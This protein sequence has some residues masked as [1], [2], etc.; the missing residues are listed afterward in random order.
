MK[1][2]AILAAA[3][4]VIAFVPRLGAHCDSLK[5]PVVAAAQ[6]ALEKGDVKFVLKWVPAT[7]EAEIRDAFAKTLAARAASPQ[8]RE[9]ADR[10]FFETLVRVHRQSEGA[11]F[12]GLQPANY[13]PEEG[14]EMADIALDSGSIDAVQKELLDSVTAGL[15]ARFA[16]VQEAKKHV[17]ESVEEG[18]HYVHAYVEFIHYVERLHAASTE[19]AGHHG[20]HAQVAEEH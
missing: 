8:A 18:R 7:S 6:T 16:A 13:K 2:Q 15:R 5:G 10:W 3:L 9:V 17:N 11:P 20:I 19:P 12:T 14:I 1:K 4:L